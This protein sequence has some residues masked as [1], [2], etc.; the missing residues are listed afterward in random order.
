MTQATL[1]ILQYNVNR[2]RDRI[3]ATLLHDPKIHKYDILVI[4]EPW[5]NSY[6]TTAHHPRKQQWNWIE[7]YKKALWDARQQKL[8]RLQRPR[9]KTALDRYTKE[10]AA[11]VW[12]AATK[13][14]PEKRNSS[15]S[16]EG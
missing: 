11:V 3:M 9:T 2:S 13:A 5:R 15:R 14:T 4:H 6:I 7:L 1:S 16:R 10:V 8:P 12:E